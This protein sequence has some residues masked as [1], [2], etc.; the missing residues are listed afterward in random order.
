MQHNGMSLRPEGG[1]RREPRFAALW[2]AHVRCGNAEDV[3]CTLL[4]VSPGGARIRLARSIALSEEF[5]VAAHG[6]GEVRVKLLAQLDLIAHLAFLEDP[7]TIALLMQ[8]VLPGSAAMPPP[9]QAPCPSL[10]DPGGLC[11]SR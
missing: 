2:P 3:A 8:A 6:F 9:S 10:G 1:L 7:Q 4:D 5:V 11:R